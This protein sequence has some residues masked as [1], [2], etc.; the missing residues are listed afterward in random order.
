MLLSDASRPVELILSTGR[1]TYWKRRCIHRPVEVLLSTGRTCYWNRSHMCR[2]VEVKIPTGR[3]TFWNC[4]HMCRPVDIHRSTGRSLLLE[5]KFLRGL[6][7][8]FFLLHTWILILI[9]I[10]LMLLSPLWPK[11]QFAKPVL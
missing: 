9:M 7:T 2:P 5:E 8:I 10:P 1:T 3:T 6:M 11:A 4:H